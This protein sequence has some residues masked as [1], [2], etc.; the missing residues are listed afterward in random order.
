[1]AGQDAQAPTIAGAKRNSPYPRTVREE[2]QLLTRR[3]LLEA[4]LGAFEANGYHGASV[5]EIVN[6]AGVTRSTFYLHFKNKSEILQVLTDAARESVVKLYAELDE[7]I[8]GGSGDVRPAVR[9]WL[10]KAIDW[11]SESEHQII[12]AVWQE[13]S[14]GVDSEGVRGI[15]VDVHLPRYLD[16]WPVEERD[17]ARTRVIL[18]SHLLSRAVLLSRRGLLPSGEPVMLETLADLW[19]AGLA[20]PSTGGAQVTRR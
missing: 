18:L 14:V 19:A 6:A 16:Q 8:A 7:D 9:R 15:S 13:L 1:M 4:A 17:A 5:E 12:A 10:E 20:R 2:Q 11:Y 3:R